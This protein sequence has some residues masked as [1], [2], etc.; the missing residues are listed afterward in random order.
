MPACLERRPCASLVAL[1]WFVV[2]AWAACGAAAQ[3]EQEDEAPEAFRVAVLRAARGDVGELAAAV[4]GVMLR[5]LAEQA[6]IEH[7]T[8]SPIDYADIRLAAG[9]NDEGRTCLEA[10][11]RLLE[12]DAVVVRMLDATATDVTLALLHFDVRTTGEPASVAREVERAGAQTALVAALPGLVRSL[13]G[14]PEPVEAAP[15]SDPALDGN[16]AVRISPL[17][18]SS[19]EPAATGVGAWTWVALIAGA[20]VLATGVAVGVSANRDFAQF[21]QMPVSAPGDALRANEML[22]AAQRKA[23]LANVLVPSG[24]AIAALGGILLVLDLGRDEAAASV[25][26]RPLPGGALLSVHGAVG[27]F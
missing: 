6:G 8:V 11:A 23:V 20:G 5:S 22:D 27:A 16:D 10:I 4:D 1:G 18:G 2:C 13:F 25:G 12:V 9:C 24:A 19:S 14:I 15:P 26:V 7:P 21:K 17:A 3:S